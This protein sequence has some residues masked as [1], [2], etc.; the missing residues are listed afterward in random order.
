MS[1]HQ[2]PDLGRLRAFEAKVRAADDE[3]VAD[4]LCTED[5]QWAFGECGPYMAHDVSVRLVR[6]IAGTVPAGALFDAMGLKP[7]KE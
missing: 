7:T 2:L 6:I 1:V 4:L 3:A 5:G